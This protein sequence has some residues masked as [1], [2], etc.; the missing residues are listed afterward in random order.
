VLGKRGVGV[1]VL[2]HAAQLFHHVAFVRT[3]RGTHLVEQGQRP[4]PQR[5]D[6]PF[7][8]AAA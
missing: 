4:A 7:R 2:A 6:V 3:G 8:H 1:I 5:V